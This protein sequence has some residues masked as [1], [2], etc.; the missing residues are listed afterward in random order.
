MASVP[1]RSLRPA[2][3]PALAPRALARRSTLPRR[4]GAIAS[5]SERSHRDLCEPPSASAPPL[6]PHPAQETECSPRMIRAGRSI[7]RKH[8]LAPAPVGRV[9]T[10]HRL[11]RRWCSIAP[12]ADFAL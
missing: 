1:E 5:V 6:A 3:A 11:A 9:A 8:S 4:W 10:Q 2:S 12:P 7:P